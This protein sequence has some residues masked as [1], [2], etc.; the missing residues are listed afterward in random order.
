MPYQ[1]SGGCH[2]PPDYDS[3]RSLHCDR[4]AE[5]SP[6]T[7]DVELDGHGGFVLVTSSPPS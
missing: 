5:V 4:P 2:T 6:H 1:T 3:S 7:E